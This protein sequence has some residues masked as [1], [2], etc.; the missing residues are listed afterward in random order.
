M[1]RFEEP[2]TIDFLPCFGA[3]FD[4]A[5]QV[6][7]CGQFQA[8]GW[9]PNVAATIENR[10]RVNVLNPGF[11]HEM[12]HLG[13]VFTGPDGSV[14]R[15]K[16]GDTV[17]CDAFSYASFSGPLTT[18]RQYVSCI[19]SFSQSVFQHEK[20]CNGFIFLS[21]HLPSFHGFSAFSWMAD[22]GLL[23]IHQE[24][25]LWMYIFEILD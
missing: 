18:Q 7:T 2:L 6:Q 21:D 11:C 14:T 5:V 17:S 23:M 24:M 16:T 8:R 1:N 10:S 4:Y 12:E 15:R 3:S 22:V 9:K 13:V 25:R 20:K 19:R